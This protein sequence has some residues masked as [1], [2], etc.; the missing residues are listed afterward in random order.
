M[1]A[2]ALRAL[3]ITLEIFWVIFYVN[4]FNSV[5]FIDSKIDRDRI[6]LKSFD[7]QT[8]HYPSLLNVQNDIKIVKKGENKRKMMTCVVS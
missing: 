8:S 3:K 7:R 4:F 2:K 6:H 1:K 5:N